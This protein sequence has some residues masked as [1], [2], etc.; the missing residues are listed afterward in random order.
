MS[1]LAELR[2]IVRAA[3]E[4]PPAELTAEAHAQQLVAR[5]GGLFSALGG[6]A[7]VPFA[8]L[9]AIRDELRQRGE[10]VSEEARQAHFDW[11]RRT[12]G[13]FKLVRG[14][15]GRPR[16]PDLPRGVPAAP[17]LLHEH[18]CAAL[19]ELHYAIYRRDHPAACDCAALIAGGLSRRP[20][21]PDLRRVGPSSDGYYFGDL[22]VCGLCGARWF[23]GIRDDDVGSR[24]WEPATE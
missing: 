17:L 15:D 13:W 6:D 1:R 2:A 7:S 19:C 10:E 11:L 14:P 21:S 4:A 23:H 20:G 16:A 3:F 24:F 8:E 5:L 22:H 18:L 12:R 9:E